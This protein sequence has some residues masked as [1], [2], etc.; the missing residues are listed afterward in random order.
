MEH[1]GKALKRLFILIA[2]LMVAGL[3]MGVYLSFQPQDLTTIS[4]YSPDDRSERATDVPA[5]IRLAAKNRQPIVLSEKQVNSWL[6]ENLKVRQ[7]GNFAKETELKGVWIRFDEAEGG[8]AEFII[9]RKVRNITHTSSMFLR[10]QRRKKEDDSFTTTVRKDGGSFLG[11]VLIGGRFGKLKIPQ[12]FLLF[13]QD[14]YAN[15][16]ALFEEEFQMIEQNIIKEGAGR[17]VF[18]EKKMRIDFPD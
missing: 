18:E 7:E 11:T 15:L 14:A 4:G 1:R 16:G 12:G 10:F 5:M 8:R 3:G 6:A 9:E 2:F 17:I 13:T